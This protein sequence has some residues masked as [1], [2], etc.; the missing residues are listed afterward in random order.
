MFILTTLILFDHLL[1][2]K[3][4]KKISTFYSSI[5]FISQISCIFS[6]IV[7]FIG[8]INKKGIEIMEIYSMEKNTSDGIFKFLFKKWRDNLMTSINFIL[9]KLKIK[10]NTIFNLWFLNESNILIDG[11]GNC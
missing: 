11:Q 8:E 4:R 2:S 3:K 1:I 5:N 7:T 10:T 6:W 9:S